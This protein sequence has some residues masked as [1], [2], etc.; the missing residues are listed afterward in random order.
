MTAAHTDAV[1]GGGTPSAIDSET[2]YSAAHARACTA[3]TVACASIAAASAS[4]ASSATPAGH[5]TT[6]DSA[7][8][9]ASHTAA[10]LLCAR[11]AAT[12][13]GTAPVRV[14]RRSSAPTASS[15]SPA[16]AAAHPHWM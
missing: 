5:A 8:E 4:M 11:S 1:S 12:I 13:N 16:N 15:Q 7:A 14:S 3:A 6:Q 2:W 9:P 10:S